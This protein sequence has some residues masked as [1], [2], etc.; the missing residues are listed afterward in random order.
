MN[1]V[2]QPKGYISSKELSMRT[3]IGHGDVLRGI[4]ELLASDKVQPML[5]TQY[6]AKVGKKRSFDT[7]LIPLDDADMIAD[8]LKT[9]PMR[10]PVGAVSKAMKAI[11]LDEYDN[12]CSV[13]GGRDD[14]DFE[15]IDDEGLLG[16][17]NIRVVCLSCKS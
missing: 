11:L 16:I 13:C 9:R 12:K 6:L 17:S 15:L 3:G 14:L 10:Y 1:I 4:R 5:M 8:Y 2:H 7:F